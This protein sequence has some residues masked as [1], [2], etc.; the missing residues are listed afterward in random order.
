[1]GN[2]ADAGQLLGLIF[3]TT[4]AFAFETQ[5]IERA[6][7]GHGQEPGQEGATQ[8]IVPC[9]VA[10]ELQEDVLNDFFSRAGLLDNAEY[11]SVN[12]AAIAVVESFKGAHIPLQKLPDKSGVGRVS[13]VGLW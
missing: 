4:L 9:G 12:E 13:V 2:G 5:I 8:S 6:V 7:A 10:P 3:A 1:L 11:Q